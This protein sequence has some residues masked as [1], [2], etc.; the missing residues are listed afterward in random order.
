[1]RLRGTAHYREYAVMDD[2]KSLSELIR[3]ETEKED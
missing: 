3:E 1:V 2:T